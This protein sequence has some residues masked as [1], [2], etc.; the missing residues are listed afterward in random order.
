MPSR[1][2]IVVLVLLALALAIIYASFP[3][4]RDWRIASWRDSPA[5]YAAFL[6]KH[7]DSTYAPRARELLKARNEALAWRALGPAPSSAMLGAFLGQFPDSAHSKDAASKLRL[8]L[9]R[10]AAHQFAEGATEAALGSSAETLTAL[11]T[12]ALVERPKTASDY[13]LALRVLV[14]YVAQQDAEVLR[15][16]LSGHKPSSDPDWLRNATKGAPQMHMVKVAGMQEAEIQEVEA[17][18]IPEGKRPIDAVYVIRGR[19][20]FA[21]KSNPMLSVLDMVVAQQQ[22]PQFVEQRRPFT[23]NVAIDRDTLF[24]ELPSERIYARPFAIH[25]AGLERGGLEG[26]MQMSQPEV[27]IPNGPGSIFRFKN[28]VKGFLPGYT[29]QGDANYPLAF[30]L[31][32][33]VGLT[34]LCGNGTVSRYDGKS[35]SFPPKDEARALPASSASGAQGTAVT[36]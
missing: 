22:D 29:F 9:M 23:A 14:S 21:S 33:N 7:G 24:T 15:V 31:L 30:V 2:P 6:K 32:E 13:E 16:V 5:A 28:T 10:T 12:N 34:Y 25:Y 36:K 26:F 17:A 3:V 1:K 27:F 4:E 20:P 11:A 19:W 35:W 18:F 8:L